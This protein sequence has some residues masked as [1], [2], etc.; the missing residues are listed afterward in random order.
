MLYDAFQYTLIALLV[1]GSALQLWRRQ[2]PASFRRARIWLALRLLKPPAPAWLRACGR[3]IAPVGPAGDV[4]C[5]GCSSG[6]ATPRR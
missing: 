2:A 1:L 6:C 3:R 5:G 4:A